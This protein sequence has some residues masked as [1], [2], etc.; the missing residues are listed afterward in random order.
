MEFLTSADWQ[1]FEQRFP[2]A[3]AWLNSQNLNNE[4][5][6]FASRKERGVAN[7]WELARLD[8]LIKNMPQTDERFMEGKEN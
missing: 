7:P 5:V 4:R 8:F 1:E 3:Q 6:L 2:S